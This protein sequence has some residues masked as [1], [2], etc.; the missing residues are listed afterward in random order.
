ML[1]ACDWKSWMSHSCTTCGH[2]EKAH[3]AHDG[4]ETC[5]SLEG[6][7]VFT[8]KDFENKFNDLCQARP[9]IRQALESIPAEQQQGFYDQFAEAILAELLIERYMKENGLTNSP[10]YKKAAQEAH[11]AVETQLMN[12]MFQSDIFKK[13]EQE[14]TDEMAEK[15]YE[16]N[17]DR[18][19]VFKRPPF[20]ESMGGVSAVAIEGLKQ[21]DAQALAARAQKEDFNQLAQELKRKVKDLGLVNGRSMDVDEHIRSKVLGYSSTPQVDVV[22]LSNGKYAVV[23]ATEIK[24]DTFKPYS[25]PEVKESV[26]SF[27]IR[28]ELGKAVTKTM[29]ELKQ[30]YGAV[31]H[32][33]VIMKNVKNAPMEM[34]EEAVQEHPKAATAA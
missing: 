25:D 13:I 26:K 8:Q 24:K 30:K 32:R 5:I 3:R 7:P 31:I 23:K 21:A 16:E 19:A 18:I 9:E 22:K 15:Y 27:L 14:I 34:H 20:I 10:E 6:K 33:D 4:S 12:S 11:A 2:H 1:P 29:E 17:R 28:N